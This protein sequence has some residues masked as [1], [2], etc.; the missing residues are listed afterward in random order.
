MKDDE[1][2]EE[3]DYITVTSDCDIIIRDIQ[4]IHAGIY[5]CSATNIYGRIEYPITVEINGGNNNL[6]N[7]IHMR[8]ISVFC[9]FYTTYLLHYGSIFQVDHLVFARYACVISC[10]YS[11][12]RAL[13][14]R[15]IF[16]FELIFKLFI[17]FMT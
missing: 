12:L 14:G 17:I 4:R 10:I 7:N 2:V 13:V 8:S 5:V 3:D 1:I 11:A 9:T 15:K 6:L 16:Y